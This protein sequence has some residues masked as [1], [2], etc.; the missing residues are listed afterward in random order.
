MTPRRDPLRVTIMLAVYA[1]FFI[2][3]DWVARHVF[4][5]LGGDFAGGVTTLLVCAIFANWLA[6]RI[7]ENRSLAAAG[8]QVNRASGWNLLFGLV[9]GIGSASL[10][11]G[12]PLLLGVAH[13]EPVAVPP[14]AGTLPF[15]TLMLAAGAAGEE[16]LFRGYGFQLLMSAAGPF[17]SIVPVGVLF[18]LMHTG[19]P[20]A[21]WFGIANT[22]G[23]GILFGYAYYRTR[24]LWLPIGLHFG[25]NFTL[26]LFGVNVS[27]LNIGVTGHQMVWTAGTVWSGGDYGPEASVLTSG[28]LVL[29]WIFI[30]KCPLRRQASPLTDPPVESVPCEPS[31]PLPS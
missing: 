26:P 31:P 27:G 22:A 8:L 15:V 23:F 5:F 2:A 17:A 11:L 14:T 19:N 6:L 24:D 12:P 9:G 10:V 18:A 7:Y 25:W 13:L 28:A 4:G 20:N 16:I 3:A 21:T 1:S 29:L 30:V